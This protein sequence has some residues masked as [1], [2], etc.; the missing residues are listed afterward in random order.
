M[1]I[2][3]LLGQDW[4]WHLQKERLS[5]VVVKGGQ[6]VG[7]ITNAILPILGVVTIVTTFIAPFIIRLGA[8]LNL[9]EPTEEGSSSSSDAARRNRFY[10]LF[11]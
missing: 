2:L 4:G 11:R 5:L 3:Q 10:D 8:K 9:S 6:D 1:I 7:A